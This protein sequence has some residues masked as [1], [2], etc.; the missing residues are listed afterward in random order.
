MKFRN[1]PAPR[2]A[3]RIRGL[4]GIGLAALALMPLSP[5]VA[6]D[7]AKPAAAA[8]EKASAP[9]PPPAS[10]KAAGEAKAAAAAKAQAQTA[11][12]AKPAFAAP[13]ECIRTGQRVIAALTRDDTGAASQFFAFYNAFKCPQPHLAQAFGCLVKYQKT[14]PTIASPAPEVVSQCWDDPA[15]L[16]RAPAPTP[17]PEPPHSG[18]N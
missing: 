3:K 4:A 11:A 1:V 12:P 16:P 7:I 15:A 2:T 6:D 13:W 18:S 5:A 14:N 17:A 8:Q 10:P 9:T